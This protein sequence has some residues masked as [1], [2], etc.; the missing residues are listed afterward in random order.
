MEPSGNKLVQVRCS[1]RPK[2]RARN[3][4]GNTTNSPEMVAALSDPGKLPRITHTL[5]Q[6]ILFEDLLARGEAADHADLARL[7]GITR[8]RVSQVMKLLWLAPDIQEEILRLPP[9]LPGQSSITV[10]D[11]NAVAD[12]VLWEDQRGSG[13]TSRKKGSYP[14]ST[15]TPGLGPSRPK[16]RFP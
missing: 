11:V 9:A 3:V 12:E 16:T 14:N 8:E 4:N 5:A 15:I 13:A 1:L 6:A 7:G 10:P 2:A